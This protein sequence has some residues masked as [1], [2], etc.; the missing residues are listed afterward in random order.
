MPNQ[1]FE[2]CLGG[3]AR[4]RREKTRGVYKTRRWQLR[5]MQVFSRDPFCM[6]GRVCGGKAPAWRSITSA[7]ST[8]RR[9]LPDGQPPRDLRRLPP[10]QDRRGEPPTATQHRGGFPMQPHSRRTPRV[11]RREKERS[12]SENRGFPVLRRRRISGAARSQ[13]SR[14]PIRAGRRAI[15][16]G[17]WRLRP[18]SR[19]WRDERAPRLRPDAP[20]RRLYEGRRRHAPA[21]PHRR[22]A[23]PAY[24]T[25]TSP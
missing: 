24:M 6:D 11:A 17:R 9:P 21:S 7:R 18:R 14:R 3:T 22:R 1:A 25:S 13:L 20:A 2:T 8:G 16:G 23:R 5:R 4:A 15:R 12:P 19:D 10:G